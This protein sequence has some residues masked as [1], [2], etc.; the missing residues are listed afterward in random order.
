LSY[1]G[2]LANNQ[3]NKIFMHLTSSIRNVSKEYIVTCWSTFFWTFFVVGM[4]QR[5][6][7]QFQ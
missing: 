6:G 3:D 2:P 5:V 7:Y 1:P 4:G